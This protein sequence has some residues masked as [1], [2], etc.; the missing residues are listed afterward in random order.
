MCAARSMLGLVAMSALFVATTAKAA[1]H[2]S[3]WGGGGVGAML[4]GAGSVYVNGHKT[5]VLSV[6]LPGDDFRIRYL[7]GSFERT[8]GIDSNTGDND[9]DYEGFDFVVTRAATE[10]PV[11]LAIGVARYEEA[12]HL[13]Y[14]DQDLGGSE[15]VHRWGPHASAFRSWSLGR[16]VE[17]WAE[18]DLHLAPYQPRQT[19]LFLDVGIGVRF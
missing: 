1:D 2:V 19:V 9:L 14:P 3:L 8:E 16:F 12:Y 6:A 7:R 17:T 4:T 15:F 18:A 5:A 13:G 10:W 11:D